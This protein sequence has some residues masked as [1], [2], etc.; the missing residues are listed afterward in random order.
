MYATPWPPECET[1]RRFLLQFAVFSHSSP[2][3]LI[4]QLENKPKAKL[5]NVDITSGGGRA[6]TAEAAEASMRGGG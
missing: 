4:F 1:V 6:T 2:G 5:G 3:K